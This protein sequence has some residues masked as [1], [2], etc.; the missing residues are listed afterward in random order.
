MKSEFWK[1]VVIDLV[2]MRWDENLNNG[3]ITKRGGFQD[4]IELLDI[5]KSQKI[6]NLYLMGVL[7]RD[8]GFVEL[9]DKVVKIYVEN[10][11]TQ[12]QMHLLW[13]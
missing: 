11:N 9:T 6:T 1:E 5:Y 2:G 7:E 4:V 10:R 3:E 12:G 13:L 8:N